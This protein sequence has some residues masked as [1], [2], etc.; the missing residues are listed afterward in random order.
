MPD[1]AAKKVG[2]VG[3]AQHHR[4]AL[5]R[6][7]PVD[8]TPRP[9][10]CTEAALKVQG[11]SAG[12]SGSA[13]ASDASQTDEIS[14]LAPTFRGSA[15]A[16]RQQSLGPTPANVGVPVPFHE[17]RPREV[18]GGYARCIGG[19]DELAAVLTIREIRGRG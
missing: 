1:L 5:V 13:S 12:G 17:R 9:Q 6:V 15:Q 7:R 3:Q 19:S 8:T 18:A 11:A 16:R 10:N 2:Q 4:H 14:E